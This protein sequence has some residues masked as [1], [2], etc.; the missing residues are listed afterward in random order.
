MIMIIMT[1]P[2]IGIFIIKRRVKTIFFI[3]NT[4]HKTLKYLEVICTEQK[5]AI[6]KKIE[7]KIVMFDIAFSNNFLTLML[8]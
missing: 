8:K 2:I 3:I 4:M 7:R 1:I 6:T 5:F